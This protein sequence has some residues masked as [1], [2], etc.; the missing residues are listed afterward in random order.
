MTPSQAKELIDTITHARGFAVCPS[1]VVIG[2]EST[3]VRGVS[4]H[5]C[6][7][8]SLWFSI[9]ATGPTL[10]AIQTAIGV[11]VPLAAFAGK[12]PQTNKESA[13]ATAETNTDDRGEG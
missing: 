6:E 4:I 10:E 1:E 3:R 5:D 2:S 7:D 11:L 12:P 8:G 13:D 9:N